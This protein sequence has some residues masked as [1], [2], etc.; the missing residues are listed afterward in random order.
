MTL[1]TSIASSDGTG[2]NCIII[3]KCLNCF[4]GGILGGIGIVL[5]ATG[6]GAPVGVALKIVGS[7]TTIG[8]ALAPFFGDDG[9][10]IIEDSKKSLQKLADDQ[11]ELSKFLMLFMESSYSFKETE[12]KFEEEAKNLLSNTEDKYMGLYSAG[13]NFFTAGANFKK[14]AAIT[15]ENS[16]L[17]R[18]H[19]FAANPLRAKI[20]AGNRNFKSMIEGSK[21]FSSLK[22]LSSSPAASKMGTLWMKSQFGQQISKFAKGLK[23]FTFKSVPTFI[24]IGIGIYKVLQG[25]QITD[26]NFNQKII[27]TARKIRHEVD[28]LFD[29]YKDVLG[30]ENIKSSSPSLS[31]SSEI[32]SLQVNA[33]NAGS[34]GT[35]V[36]FQ[37]TNYKSEST[38]MYSCKT[39]SLKLYNGWNTFDVGTQLKKCMHFEIFNSK[40]S[41]I[42]IR[43]KKK[44]FNSKQVTLKNIQLSTDGNFLPSLDIT[45]SIILRKDKSSKADLKKMVGLKAIK[46]H[47]SDIAYAGTDG[48]LRAQLE[49]PDNPELRVPWIELD[50]YG[51][52]RE[53][54]Q[55]DI[56]SGRVKFYNETR[57]VNM[58]DWV[59]D[60]EYLQST[61]NIHLK[62]HF[63]RW[64]ILQDNWNVDLIKLYLTGAKGENQVMRCHHGEKWLDDGIGK[65]YR[66]KCNFMNPKNPERSLQLIK[67]HT[68]DD[69]YAGISA[70]FGKP[71]PIQINICKHL[72]DLTNIPASVKQGNCCKTNKFKSGVYQNEWFDID[73][74]TTM[75]VAGDGGH[76]LGGCE[77]FDMSGLKQV[78]VG[79]SL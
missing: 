61:K 16:I 47:T 44:S 65:G 36:E 29:A 63:S 75:E 34:Y 19:N 23:T 40:I 13:V 8:G 53:R 18:V 30:K 56:Y 54:D 55:T 33:E 28:L 31:M 52:D 43:D 42:V 37:F 60:I 49:F 46:M 57:D 15:M 12:S 66:F 35:N 64:L 7:L 50:N 3:F 9:I 41:V 69:Y 71:D 22:T 32:Y 38:P 24:D 74:P 14:F 67:A 72:K 2:V 70:V 1:Y 73:E 4:V 27:L 17:S 48:H 10:Q 51:D 11:N 20:I 77:Y 76:D 58:R 68:C 6:V 39:E 78:F 5:T 79:K 45:K 59:P 25:K 21:L 62:L 26:D